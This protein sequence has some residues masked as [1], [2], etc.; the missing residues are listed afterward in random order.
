[1]AELTTWAARLAWL[2]NQKPAC[3]GEQDKGHQEIEQ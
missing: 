1:M 3:Q 2:A